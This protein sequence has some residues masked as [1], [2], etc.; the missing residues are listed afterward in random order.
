VPPMRD[1]AADA[2]KRMAKANFAGFDGVVELEIVSRGWASLALSG[3]YHVLRLS[4]AGPAAAAAA[5]AFLEGLAE[6]EVALG[7]QFLADIALLSDERAG[8][9]AVVSLHLE[10]LTVAG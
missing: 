7:D 8:D 5:D 4:L 2:L 6:R 10:A 3:E 9:G 1:S